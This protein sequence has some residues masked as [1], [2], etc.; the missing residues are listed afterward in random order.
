MNH[1]TRLLADIFAHYVR[2]I[3]LERLLKVE[4]DKNEGGQEKRI[5]FIS[6]CC[7][8]DSRHVS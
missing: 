6:C 1:L 8:V 7:P 3:V 5:A 4:E 2:V